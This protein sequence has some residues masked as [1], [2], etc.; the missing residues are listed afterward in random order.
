M[1]GGIGSRAGVLTSAYFAMLF[2]PFGVHLPF[3][4]V[5]L[6][7]WGLSP[8][9]IGAYTAAGVAVRIV[10]GMMI[11]ILAEWLDQRRLTL[12]VLS[13]VG[14]GLF[15]LHALVEEKA[16]LFLLTLAS[17]G[18][19]ASLWPLAEALGNA[20][21]RTAPFPYAQARG[22]GS[23]AFLATNVVGGL[24]VARYGS[25]AVLWWMVATLML[26]APL[27]LVHPGGGK[28]GRAN[29][30]SWAD[31]RA[32]LGSPVFLLFAGATAL[33]QSSHG[34]LYVLASVHWRA[35]GIGDGTI[36][37]LWAIGVGAEVLLMV[38]FGA[39]LIGWLGPVGAM[40]LGGG[41][42]V[43]RWGLMC[44]DP[45]GPW[46]WLLQAT[47][48]LSFAL[49][50]LGLMAFLQMTVSDRMGATGQALTVQLAGGVAMAAAM[51]AAGAAYPVLGG[52]IYGVAAAMAVAGTLLALRLRRVWD[53]GPLAIAGV[54]RTRRERARGA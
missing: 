12:A 2:L 10:S 48:A 25:G 49:T 3:W 54:S 35:L 32:L 27:A 5:W 15:A 24:L 1:S 36:G 8:A 14:S 9:E 33:I 11:P 51:A 34:V 22:I 16:A 30:A 6:S 28:V 37:A 41:A 29:R 17:A 47:H 42:A 52:G 39:R 53:G 50:H 45:V 44:L 40:V 38:V 19:F 21:A 43:L 31:R 13:I 23:A 7:D 46:L 18:V 4:P 26:A 20:A